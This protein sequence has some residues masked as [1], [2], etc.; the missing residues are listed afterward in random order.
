MDK[1]VVVHIYNEMLFSHKK[2]RFWVSSSEVNEPRAYYTEGSKSERE[3][4]ISY[5]S[6]HD[7]AREGEGGTNWHTK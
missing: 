7:T 5:I 1:E 4:Q 2:K 6:A 3:Q